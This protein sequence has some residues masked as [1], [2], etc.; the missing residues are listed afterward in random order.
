MSAA[1]ARGYRPRDAYRANPDVMET[2]DMLAAGH[3]SR[4]DR[5]LFRPLVDTLLDHDEYMLLADYASY[6]E[7]QDGIS[8]AY[9]DADRWARMS[10]LNV[11]RI[12]KFSS[13]R[14]IR[15]YCDEIW[16]AFPVHVG[17]DGE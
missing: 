13:D 10:I 12:G 1:K 14:A 6:L 8:R 4:G 16:K 15:E 5:A 11:A 2:L 9:A 7:C 3:F 17:L